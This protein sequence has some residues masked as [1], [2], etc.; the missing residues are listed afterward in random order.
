MVFCFVVGLFMSWFVP[1][2]LQIFSVVFMCLFCM[3]M[4]K[5]P[6][7]ILHEHFNTH[8]SEKESDG[9]RG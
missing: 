6:I 2:H 7:S 3:L 9:G 5:S 8:T 1:I 4:L